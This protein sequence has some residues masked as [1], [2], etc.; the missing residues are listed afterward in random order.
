MGVIPLFS[1]NSCPLLTVK[2]LFSVVCVCGGVFSFCELSALGDT[3]QNDLGKL[4]EW[5]EINR[6]PFT[7]NITFRE[8]ISD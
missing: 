5:L 1:K 6:M 2:M 8:E 7:T 4:K 3:V